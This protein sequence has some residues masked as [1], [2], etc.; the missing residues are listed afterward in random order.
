MGMKMSR[1]ALTTFVGVLAGA[2]L[3]IGAGPAQAKTIGS[4]F[5]PDIFA[6]AGTFF[7]PDAPSPCLTLGIG[8]H[9]VNP[10]TEGC[11][12]VLL[13]SVA[14]TADDGS[15]DSVSLFLPPPTPAADAVTGIVLDPSSQSI[16]VGINTQVIPLSEVP[17]SCSGDF[18]GQTW[19]IQWDSGLPL[20]EED[21]AAY[22]SYDVWNPLDGL[23]NRV[24]LYEDCTSIGPNCT[25]FVAGTV[26][27]ASVP[28]PASLGLLL[29]AL[30][31]GW[32]ARR[33]KLAA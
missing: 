23:N 31:A 3:M 1:R 9:A 13:Q 14:L 25:P 17:D 2:S 33:R 30:G 15:G 22:R 21:Y 26:T 11:S 4:S 32:L 24:L 29:G 5:D 20:A 12:G 27:F 16:V 10:G 19:S 7:V 8:F 18:C 6:G 28:E